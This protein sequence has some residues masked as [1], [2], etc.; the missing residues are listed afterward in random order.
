M[1]ERNLFVF[2]R[3][4]LFFVGDDISP[5]EKS[6]ALMSKKGQ[7]KEKEEKKERHPTYAAKGVTVAQRHVYA[8]KCTRSKKEEGPSLRRITHSHKRKKKKKIKK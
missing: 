6:L 5:S 3:I 2:L 1:C 7:P 8:K 4:H